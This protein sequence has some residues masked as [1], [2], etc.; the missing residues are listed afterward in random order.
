MAARG[1]PREAQADGE[2]GQRQTEEAGLDNGVAQSHAV[3]AGA[4]AL[5]GDDQACRREAER[6]IA[7]AARRSLAPVRETGVWALGILHLG[8]GRYED[9]LGHLAEIAGDGHEGRMRTPLS[10]YAAAPDLVEAAARA[11]HPE[12]ATGV[13]ERLAAWH[14]ATGA[15]WVAPLLERSRGLLARGPAAEA[16]LRRALELHVG[17]AP[18]FHRARTELCLGELLRRDRRRADSRTHLRAAAGVFD[19]LGA[20]P[21]AERA[22][23]E[24]R[25]TGESRRRPRRAGAADRTPQERRIARFVAEGASNQ[26]VAAQ[27]F[28]SPKTV[29]YHL[30]KV[31]QKL[32][33]SSRAELARLDGALS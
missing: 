18:G 2:E 13:L 29:E 11:G 25:A 23:E 10:L 9:A 1:H 30:A 26:E 4:A 16:H 15:S 27:L 32:G 12:R 14:Q 5:R 33:I 6:A 8:R 31:F 21:W 19:A 3:L 22:R 24:L 17:D 20:E 7:V 28:L